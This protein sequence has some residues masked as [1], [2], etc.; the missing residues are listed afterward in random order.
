MM[1]EHPLDYARGFIR[2]DA[3][4]FRCDIIADLIR[5]SEITGRHEEF[6]FLLPAS[7][8]VR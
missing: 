2:D 3:G 4:E 1:T 7:D 8:D 5:L 6:D